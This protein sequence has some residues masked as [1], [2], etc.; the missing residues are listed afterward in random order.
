MLFAKDGRQDET[1]W[2]IVLCDGTR[3]AMTV[4]LAQARKLRSEALALMIARARRGVSRWLTERVRRLGQEWVAVNGIR[5]KL[6]SRYAISSSGRTAGGGGEAGFVAGGKGAPWGIEDALRR[7]FVIGPEEHAA[8]RTDEA[9]GKVGGEI[10]ATP[11]PAE[12]ERTV[13]KGF[14]RAA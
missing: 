9:L 8:L 1:G 14:S 11:Q 10:V 7:A 4:V 13:S 12:P 3:Q 6:P 2:T 5:R